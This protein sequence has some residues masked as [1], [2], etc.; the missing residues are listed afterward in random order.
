M[1]QPWVIPHQ[2][3][4]V[5]EKSALLTDILYQSAMAAVCVAHQHESGDVSCEHLGGS[6]LKYGN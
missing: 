3:P 2:C 1:L 4:G 5:H 6:S